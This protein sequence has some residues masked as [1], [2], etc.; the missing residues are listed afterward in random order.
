MIL[1]LTI[2]FWIIL[3]SLGNVPI[4]AS[5]LKHLKP[6]RQRFVIIREM[7]I[8]LGIMIFFLFF[9]EAFFS[10]LDVN[11]HA[12]EMTG[13]LVLFVIA[14]N[15]IFA[16]PESAEEVDDAHFKEPMIVPL[17]IPAT[18]G[19]AILAALVLYG[20]SETH[21]GIVL[22]ALV[23]AWL[24]SLP[25]LLLSP[26]LKRFLGDNGTAAIERLFGYLLV[27]IS[28]QMTIHGLLGTFKF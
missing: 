14:L 8:A 3:D 20:G 1:H 2:L 11:Q 7:L 9:G 18:A 10:I 26:L 23:L 13:G 6:N 15:M 21:R 5:Q 22:I 25:I 24:F 28:T 19:P 12:L 16:K 4:F 27:L 17:A